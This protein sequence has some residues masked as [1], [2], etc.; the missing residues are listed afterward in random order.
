M[1]EIRRGN[2]VEVIIETP[3]R[4]AEACGVIA[5]CHGGAFYFFKATILA[6]GL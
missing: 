3:S 5:P 2:R 4:F 6:S 1:F